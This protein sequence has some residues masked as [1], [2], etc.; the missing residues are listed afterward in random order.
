MP[1]DP[2]EVACSLRRAGEYEKRVACD[3]SDRQV[4]FEAAAGVQ[5]RRVHDAVD[6][7]VDV[8]RAEALQYGERVATFED[9]LGKRR[10]VE[11]DDILATGTLF[12]ENVRQPGGRAE[13]VRRC[14]RAVR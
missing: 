8:V 3:A 11:D 14:R 5:H 9:E 1:L 4:A 6:R 12:L 10:L 7:N 13:R 2:G